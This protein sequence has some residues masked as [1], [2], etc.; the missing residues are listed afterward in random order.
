MI[1]RL[2]IQPF[3]SGA[4]LLYLSVHLSRAGLFYLPELVNSYLTDL[5]CLP[6]ILTISLMVTRLI[7][8]DHSISLT[9]L[10]IAGMTLFYAWYFE[11][12]LPARNPHYTADIIDV[13]CYLVGAFFY[14]RIIQPSFLQVNN[15]SS[16]AS[17]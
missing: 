11:W 6:I 16:N 8:R 4:F 3:F 14:W 13:W 7:K 5:L 12:Y 17:H 1:K 10:M 9:L 2:I 15:S